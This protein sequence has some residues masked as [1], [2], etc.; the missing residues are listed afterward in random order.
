MKRPTFLPYMVGLLLMNAGLV[1]AGQTTLT[2]YYPAPSGNYDKLRLF[3]QAP[4][5]GSCLPGTIYVENTNNTLQY[6]GGSS[7]WGSVGAWTQTG[8][9][10][11]PNN[12]ASNVG[13]GGAAPGNKLDVV[14]NI[15]NSVPSQGWLGLTGDLPGYTNNTHPTLKTNGPWI[16]FSANGRYTGYIGSAGDFALNNTSN[17]ENVYLSSSGTS[18]FNGG[19]VGIGLTNPQA[20]LDVYNGWI[21]P[22][23]NVVTDTN[24]TAG[25]TWYTPGPTSYGIYRTAGGW[26]APS[27]QQLQLSWATGIVIDGGT[28][29]GKSGTVLQPNGGNV[30]IGVTAPGTKLQVDGTIRISSGNYLS[31]LDAVRG[32]GSY[33]QASGDLIVSTSG[34]EPIYFKDSGLSGDIN[35]TI[36]GS[37]G[38]VGIGVTAPSEKLEVNGNIKVN[39]SVTATGGFFYSDRRL[40][41]DIRPLTHALDTVQ[42]LN[43][44]AFTWKKNNVKSVGV[45]AQN[46]EKVVPELVS[47]DK[48]GMK[49]VAYGNLTALLIEAV[50]EQQKEIEGLKKQV[51][52]LQ[53]KQPAH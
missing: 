32:E 6:C 2:T 34:G 22:Q 40:K 49:S 11:Y 4:L 13:I 48:D 12:L 16:Y 20:K 38:N 18:Y 53:N 3:P 29:Y 44:V 17:V 33:L 52:Q 19:N 46:A 35:M 43:G 47:T 23:N 28:L 37:T 25:I 1:F 9:N 5:S 24:A 14:G 15:V 7:V 36:L 26:N 51:V 10:L 27:Y 50:K 21:T 42:R 31:L 45:I 30:G 39:G 8:N 41:K